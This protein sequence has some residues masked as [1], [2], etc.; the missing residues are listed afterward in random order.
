MKKKKATVCPC[1]S[2]HCTRDSLRCK[3]GRTYFEK[4]DQRAAEQA[5]APQTEAA[6][7]CKH[8]WAKLVAPDGLLFQLLTVSCKAKKALRSGR[9]T[10]A[11]LTASLT[12][13]NRDQLSSLLARLDDFLNES[14]KSGKL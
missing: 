4:L 10:E 13:A 8:K 5:A 9:L 14:K 11:Q 1:C 3:Y 6:R 7:S 12:E 2:R